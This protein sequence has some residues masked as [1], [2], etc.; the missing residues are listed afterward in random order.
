M[1]CNDSLLRSRF[2]F[3][4]NNES[5][6]LAVPKC[7]CASVPAA[8]LVFGCFETAAATCCHLP[9]AELEAAIKDDNTSRAT[10]APFGA[11]P[12]FGLNAELLTQVV[13]KVL[14]VRRD[15]D[16]AARASGKLVLACLRNFVKGLRVGLD[17][18]APRRNSQRVQDEHNSAT[19]RCFSVAFL[20]NAAHLVH[21]MS[22]LSMVGKHV[23]VAENG[24]VFA[25]DVA[26]ATLRNKLSS[27]F[28]PDLRAIGIQ[29]L[30]RH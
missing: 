24:V 11:T 22:E 5:G 9:G 6:L 23:E 4:V 14:V 29:T 25:A 15:V 30:A 8:I 21:E 16:V 17:G 3:V 20:P 19:A 27:V 7:A 10:I 12:A 18:C 13:L 28:H 2:V 26:S 1:H